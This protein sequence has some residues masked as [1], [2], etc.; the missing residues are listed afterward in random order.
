MHFGNEE[1]Q[2]K[3]DSTVVHPRRSHRERWTPQALGDYEVYSNT[4]TNAK[5]K[6]VHFF[7]LVELEPVS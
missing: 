1:N 4:T 3:N 7:L 5:E 6:L 2:G